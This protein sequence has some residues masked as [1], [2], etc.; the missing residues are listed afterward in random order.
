M[1]TLMGRVLNVAAWMN[2][3]DS[4]LILILNKHGRFLVYLNAAILPF[5]RPVRA[6]VALVA[7]V[8]LA[9]SALSVGVAF[10]LA[11]IVGVLL[12]LPA[13]PAAAS[14]LPWAIGM[15]AAC[16]IGRGLCLWVRDQL[17]MAT[18]ARVKRAVRSTLMRKV[19]DLGPG[20]ADTGGRGGLQ[21]TAVDG[22]EHLQGY[23]GFYLPQL[24][25]S[26]L[27][28]AA[29]AVVL[30]TIDPWVALV[31][32]VCVA[33]VPFAQRIWRF[34]LRKRAQD[35]WER[36]GE[37][38]G[39]LG[40]TVHGMTTLV[41]LGAVRRRREHM[42]R[43]AD[44]LREATT[45]NMRASLG[46][47]AV[48]A[49]AMSI[50]TAGATLVAAAD[51]AR[52]VLPVASVLLV[53]F[54]AAEAF[55]PQQDLSGY[56]HEGFY[57]IAAA[58]GIARLL[59]TKPAVIDSAKERTARVPDAPAL[60]V[61]SVA[62]AF[63]GADRSVLK[64]VSFEIPGGSTLA[65]VAPSGAGKTP[66]GRRLLRDRDPDR[67]RILL[68]GRALDQYPL[69]ALRRD[70]ARVAQDVVLLS[71]TIRDNVALA[72]PAAPEPE[73]TARIAQ[74]ITDARLDEVAASLDDGLDSHV[75]EG[76]ILLSGGQR[77]RVALAR[78]LVGEAK[79][80][81]LDE[82]T[83]ALDAEN[84]RLITEVLRAQRG[85]RTT[86]V[87]AHRLSTVAH[88]DYV[89]ALDDGG[90]AEF[91]PPDEL[92]GQGGLWS[93]LVAAQRARTGGGR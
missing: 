63:P 14:E 53:L 77:Q 28:P 7:L 81:L 59:E 79:L 26:W 49:A 85:I 76:G 8:A 21:T 90:V 23:I 80:L 25:V 61:D 35:H 33:I 52:G 84:E 9:S 27:V 39:R 60:T 43:A 12:R 71:G 54:L 2:R 30:L 19:F 41:A 40:D 74:A 92:S 89:L 50:G 82:A 10:G 1:T 5:L 15:A 51:A 75:G 73:R 44:E 17:A 86:V 55:R 37:F 93:Q 62:F 45:A 48:M 70:T 3:A 4:L 72:A 56:W 20:H 66:H 18:A 24:V 22:V 42:A 36:Y 83:S 64:D 29:V 38:A 31:V 47:S 87:I 34:L 69:P 11:A 78:A 16:A 6:W 32:V 91:G 46:V 57:G 58:E 65:I 67:G 88:A 13:D 68:A